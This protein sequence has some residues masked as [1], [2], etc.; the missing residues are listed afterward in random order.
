MKI[1]PEVREKKLKSCTNIILNELMGLYDLSRPELSEILGVP[2]GRVR[3][4]LDRDR[5]IADWEIYRCAEFFKVP[6]VY[7]LYGIW[8]EEYEKK[9]NK[10][11]LNLL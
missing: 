1:R 8:E 10:D 2:L 11:I 9:F 5:P 6:V 7:L 4:W 3:S